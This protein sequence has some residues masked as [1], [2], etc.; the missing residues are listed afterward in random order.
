MTIPAW[1]TG[2]DVSDGLAVA[3][4]AAIAYGVAQWSI[5]AAWVLGGVV[6]VTPAVVAAIRKGRR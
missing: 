5:P 1:I 6:L 2:I 4:L 3:G